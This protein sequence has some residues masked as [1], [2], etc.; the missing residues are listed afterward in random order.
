MIIYNVTVC[1]E[2]SIAQ[3]W[4]K[5]MIKSHIPEALSSELILKAQINQIFS[6][7]EFDSSFAVAYTFSCLEEF[8]KYE[9]KFAPKL[10]TIHFKKFG[11]KA[12]SFRTLMNVVKEF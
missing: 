11:D 4:L 1:V 10:K 8:K 3:D 12:N 7:P 5:W 2:K 9:L 6:E